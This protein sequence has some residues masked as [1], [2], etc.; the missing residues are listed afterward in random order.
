MRKKRNYLIII[1]VFLL[2]TILTIVIKNNNQNL[3]YYIEGEPKITLYL[4]Q[5]NEVIELGLE[6]YLV[7]VI[8]AEMPASFE[9]EALKAQAIAARTYTIRKIIE[10]REY[11]L[12]ADLSDNIN[13]CQ[14]Y[15]SLDEFK[16]RNPKNYSELQEKLIKAVY[17]T[18]GEIL[19]YQNNEVIDALYHSTCG[20]YTE[21]AEDA[22]GNH[23][24]YLKSIK[25]V[26]CEKSRHY[27]TEQVFSNSEFNQIF[28]I[29]DA[30]LK[31]DILE[32]SNSGRI[33]KMKINNQIIYG[34]R[35][36]NLL[37]LPSTW[38]GIEINEHEVIINNRGYGHGVGMCQYGTNGMAKEGYSYEEILNKYYQNIDIIKISY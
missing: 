29:N 2:I 27:E 33:K 22:W 15:I 12:N 17:E 34:D 16:K 4:H 24:P 20:G 23:V 18:K 3:D 26:Y 38:L 7:G 19:M 35:L 5:E 1:S 11:P 36:R 9:L 8:A 31:I 21:S 25:C 6:E 30:Q 14:A 32:K 28:N 13:E 10:G 37:S